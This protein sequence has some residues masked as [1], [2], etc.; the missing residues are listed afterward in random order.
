MREAGMTVAEWRRRLR[1]LHAVRLLAE[2]EPVTTVAL[3]IGYSSVSAFIAV[4]RKAF[5]ATP[6]RYATS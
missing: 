6:G 3:E 2:G 4:I 5:G 1:L